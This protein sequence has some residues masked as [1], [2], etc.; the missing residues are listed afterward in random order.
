[1]PSFP[2]Q[3]SELILYD[4]RQETWLY[5]RQPALLVIAW[6]AS[7]VIPA[8]QQIEQE[9]EQGGRYAA[10]FLAYEAAPAFD[11]AF[12]VQPIH[13]RPF[14]LLWFGIY[15]P[16]ERLPRQ[17]L[18][19][20]PSRLPVDWLADITERAYRR[21]I[22]EIKSYIAQGETYQVNFTYR[23]HA[24]CPA[25][26]WEVFASLAGDF[27]PPFAGY[28]QTGGWAIGSLSPELFF[29]LD[30]SQITSRPMKGT[31]PRGLTPAEDRR[32][33][34]WLKRSTKNRA[35]NVM[36]VDMVRN[37]LGR[38]AQTGTVQVQKLFEVEKYPTV[39]QMTSTV[40]AETHASLAEIFGALFPPA[41]ITGAPKIRTMQLI[42]AL[43]SSPRQI[44]TG[45][46]GYYAPGRQACFNV[47]IRTLLVDQDARQAE[48]GVGGGIVWDSQPAEEWCETQTK[49][50][51]LAEPPRPFELL[52]T[53]RWSPDAGWYLLEGHLQR[54][55]QSAGYFDFH[56]DLARLRAGLDKLAAGFENQP[57]RVRLLLNRAGDLKVE[58]QPLQPGSTPL[59][60]CLAKE[61][62]ASRDRFLYHKTTRREVY[63]QARS[64]RPGYADVL[65]WNERRELTESTI[66]NL[67]VEL[68]DGRRYTPPVRCGLLAGVYRAWLLKTGQVKERVLSVDELPR[69]Q[70]IFLANSVRGLWEVNLELRPEE[71]P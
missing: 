42:H 63:A 52:E 3:E 9:V 71:I 43:E 40:E 58:H 10:G 5:F 27:P 66:A 15:G 33:A 25:S 49:A 51:A 57:Q 64:S 14:P 41:S 36:I 19:A 48:Y 44:Y 16:P 35:E 31:A 29:S 69:F 60:V 21:S 62:I 1:M 47:A 34:A 38:I 61:S 37:D 11:P 18:P 12:Q 6:Q 24:A 70:R 20:E 68:D 45:T 4:H 59:S 55:A 23:L 22:R 46:L 67:V 30:D 39:W 2:P 13:G 65:L 50:R 32:Q 26:A 17:A 28:L 54:L 56:L 53:L 7:Q 8:L